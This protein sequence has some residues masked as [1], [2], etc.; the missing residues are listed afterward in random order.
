MATIQDSSELDRL[1]DEHYQKHK[2]YVLVRKKN[3]EEA[4][5]FRYSPDQ[6]IS[7]PF[8]E[9][10]AIKQEL[11]DGS[12]LIDDDS[13]HWRPWESQPKA[14]YTVYTHACSIYQFMDNL[15]EGHF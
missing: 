14:E 10:V 1:N 12:I 4:K 8:V 11:Y 7:E 13:S 6:K 2:G 15:Y 9:I 5:K 3:G